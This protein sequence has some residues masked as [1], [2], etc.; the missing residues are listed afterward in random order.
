MSKSKYT[1][2]FGNNQN[3]SGTMQ[4]VVFDKFFK[5]IYHLKNIPRDWN[6]LQVHEAL[7]LTHPANQYQAIRLADTDQI[8]TDT[9]TYWNGKLILTDSDCV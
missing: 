4:V 7:E 8:C 6:F 3:T 1:D 9:F 2:L 5:C